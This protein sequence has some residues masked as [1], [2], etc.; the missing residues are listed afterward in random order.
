MADSDLTTALRMLRSAE[1]PSDACLEFIGSFSVRNGATTVRGFCIPLHLFKPD[2]AGVMAFLQGRMVQYC[3]S[4]LEIRRALDPCGQDED[5][6]IATIQRLAA[7]ARRAFVR[8][9][10][11]KSKSGECGEMLLY[12]LLESTYSAPHLIS[13]M[14][15]KTAPRV[16]FHGLDAIHVGYDAATDLLTL[17][18]GESK[19]HAQFSRGLKSGLD[20]LHA[21]MQPDAREF[22]LDLIR[23]HSLEELGDL[24]EAAR[25]RI[26]SY[27]D[28]YGPTKRSRRDLFVLLLSFDYDE[29]V[30][31]EGED[32][33]RAYSRNLRDL[34][35]GKI[36]NAIASGL[37]DRRFDQ[38]DIDIILLPVESVQ[39]IR[40][41]FD[42]A[43]R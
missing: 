17:Y 36:E 39:E 13:K 38:A 6:K 2:V 28:P 22:E 34:L 12:T 3:L 21:A 26:L 19:M 25:E 27:L 41:A 33:G 8:V 40:D 16:H 30:A 35:G 9:E 18:L 20:S 37:G 23:R 15:L 24:D 10:K 5:L 29:I 31:E 32:A 4:R 1:N 43:I 14:S 11:G 7:R 42:K